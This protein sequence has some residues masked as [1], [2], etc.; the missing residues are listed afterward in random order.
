ML[1][2]AT[3][4]G[5]TIYQDVVCVRMDRDGNRSPRSSADVRRRVR[6]FMANEEPSVRAAVKAGQARVLDAATMLYR[7][8]VEQLARRD[9]TLAVPAASTAREL[10]Q[11]GLFDGRALKALAARR[12]AAGTLLE[13]S[14]RRL[15]AS[16]GEGTLETSVDLKAVLL[17][18][19][20]VR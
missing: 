2:V 13:E 5:T 4:S 1:T 17:A 18:R 19:D 10:V 8:S 9:A 3:R 16:A 15:A 11:V 20:R 14:R 12:R 6:A 7:E